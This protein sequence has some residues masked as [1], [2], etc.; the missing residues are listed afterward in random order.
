MTEADRAASDL[1]F[2]RQV[3]ERRGDRRNLSPRWLG[4]MWGTI[5]L[6][7]CTW[8]DVHPRTCWM[9]WAVAPTVAWVLSSVLLGK[10]AFMMG[11]WDAATGQKMGLHWSTCFF[12]AVPILLMAFAGKINGYQ[13]GQLLIL[14]SGIVYYL[15]GVHF[16]RRW[17]VPGLVL[18]AG[19]V[20]L[21]F[22]PRGGWTLVGVLAF[23][24]LVISF[25]REPKARLAA[26]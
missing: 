18:M 13:M 20:V 12:A 21:T 25:W 22:V 3:V 24:A 26:A 15:G 4:I 17:M 8:N 19:A 7:G 16:D 2:V 11:E 23:L 1:E 9:F 5:I 10:D 14:V 6:I